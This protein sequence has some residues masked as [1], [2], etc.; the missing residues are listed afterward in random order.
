MTPQ[1]TQ[2]A[3]RHARYFPLYHFFAL[4]VTSGYAAL[5]ISTAF[6][7]PSVATVSSALWA[8]AIVAAVV[9]SRTMAVSVQ[10]RV[11]RLEETLRMQ[12]LLP[13]DM[14]GDIAKLSRG[15]IVALRF[16]SD[17]ELPGLV[18]RAAGGELADQKSIKEAIQTWRADW[19]RA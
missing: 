14:V 11:I 8:L 12:R 4:P 3:R 9:A 7:E 17:A 16:A 6:Q 5:A 2:S 15:Q 18:R 10:D 1:R 13:A 19:L